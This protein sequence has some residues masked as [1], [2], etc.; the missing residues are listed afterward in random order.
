MLLACCLGLFTASLRAQP[1][2]EAEVSPVVVPRAGA[3]VSADASFAGRR[4]TTWQQDETEYLLLEGDAVYRMGAYV[5]RASQALVRIETEA[6]DPEPIRHLAIYLD[7]AR[8]PRGVDREAVSAEADQLLV[9]GSTTGPIKLAADRLVRADAP[10]ADP[11]VAAGLERIA[12]YDTARQAPQRAQDPPRPSVTAEISVAVET[13]PTPPTGPTPADAPPS[14]DG[15]DAAGSDVPASADPVLPTTGTVRF[16]ADRVVFD[17]EP[18]QSVLM[19]IGNVRLFYED[20]EQVRSVVLQAERAVVFLEPDVDEA[21]AGAA[22]GA[23]EV[24]GIYLEDNIVI[25]DGDFTLRAPRIFY[26]LARD[27]A[28]VLDAVLYTWDVQRQVPLYMRAEAVRQTSRTSFEASGALLSTS[29]FA[30]PHFAIGANRVTLGMGVDERG[31]MRQRFSASHTTLRVGEVP[32]FYWPY[33]AAE[34]RDLPLRAIAGGQSRARGFEVETEWDVLALAGVEAP[35]GVDMTGKLDYRGDSGP[36]LGGELDYDL[37]GTHGRVEGYLLPIDSANDRVGDRERIDHDDDT[38]GFIHAQHRQVLPDNW[39]ADVELAYVSDEMFLESFFSS[40][41]YNAKPYQSSL[42]LR[43]QESEWA[44]DL[45]VSGQ[46]TDFTE[47]LTTLQSPGFQVERMPE[48]GYFR[49]GT[50]LLD[51]RLTWYSENR[52]SRVR[53]DFGRD[54]PGDRGFD[55]EMAQALF[56]IDSDVRFRDAAA[57]AGFPR[58]WRLRV[59]TRQEITMPLEAGPVHLTPYAVGRVTGY[60]DDFEAYAG[61]EEQFRLWGSLGLRMSTQLH[62]RYDTIESPLLNINRLRHIIE[63][64]IDLFLIG[65]TV[66]AGDLPPYDRDIEAIGDGSGV[67]LGLRQTFQTQRGGPGRWRSVD[68]LTLQT[69]FVFRS[70]DGD[71]PREPIARYF[72]YR[73]EYALGG[74]HF[75]SRALWM[76]S[77][78]LGVTGELTYDFQDNRV[79]QWRVG[80]SLDHTPRLTSFVQ[81]RDIQPIDSRLFS[82]GFTYQL[83][84]KYTFSFAHRLDLRE[85]E[86]RNIDLWL[87]RRLPRARLRILASFDQVDDEQVFGVVLAPEGFITDNPFG[88]GGRA[89]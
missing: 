47:Q 16:T 42:Y 29:E 67:R 32:V 5:F 83:T 4:V 21:A 7:D 35:D 69:D 48:L 39:Y 38:R 66:D 25:T 26:D 41:A 18:E 74:D 11:L 17:R 15:D 9:T 64:S 75:Y 71:R 1:E 79:S 22:F 30:Q 86:S 50:S 81:Y 52:F 82:Y 36:G 58:D 27:Q 43:K 54:T 13:G 57:D 70:R 87:E 10:P 53:A 77:D 2:P 45:W 56:G 85:N 89:W 28:V 84:T 24:T 63:P 23:G 60:D 65:S 40:E 55:D 73:P 80:A 78:T 34:T 61:E 31:V 6:R 3:V 72:D 88:L 62:R 12:R 33:L 44:A 8:S 37:E 51:D 68:W 46:L 49:T 59:D 19:L 14:P 76:V 20:A